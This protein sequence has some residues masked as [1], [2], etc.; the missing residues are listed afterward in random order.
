LTTLGAGPAAG[1]AEYCT[2]DDLFASTGF[3][4]IEGLLIVYTFA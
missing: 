3:A 4:P 2:K 1:A